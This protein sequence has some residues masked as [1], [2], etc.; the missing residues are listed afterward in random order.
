MILNYQMMV[1]RYPNLNEK[2]DDSNPG[3]EISS[4]PEGKVAR[5]S[6]ASSALALAYRPSVSKKG[7]KKKLQ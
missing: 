7:K 5:W 1:D 4:V 3:C 2:V 6:T